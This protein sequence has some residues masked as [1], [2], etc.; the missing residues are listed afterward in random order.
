M[1]HDRPDVSV[2]VP[3]YNAMP[4]LT[5]CLTSLVG[6]SIGSNRMEIV[7]VNDGSTD[8][9]GDELGR[10][11]QLHPR[12]FTVLHQSNSGGPGGPCNQGLDVASGRFVF[13]LGA[14][15]TLWREALERLVA[16]ADLYGSD[17]VAGKMVGVNG[18]Y[19]HQALFAQTDH[20]VQ[21]FSSALP[22]SDVQH[23]AVPSRAHR[24]ART[25]LS[26]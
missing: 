4:Y 24:T 18:R 8:S 16:E 17:V 25:A 13:F 9:S 12:L 11:E 23:K 1:A 14:D 6:Q 3:V 22:W 7:A 10:F 15:D 26:R 21:L 20:D 2:I 5:E 19:V